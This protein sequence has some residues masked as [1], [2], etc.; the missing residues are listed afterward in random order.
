M[1]YGF[2]FNK[3]YKCFR[4]VKSCYCKDITP[5]DTGIKFVL[6]MHPK[7]AFKQK[8]GTGRLTSLSLIDSEIIIGTD[9]SRNK[10]VNA[11][12]SGVGE[13]AMYY[14]VL[15]FPSK[16]ASFADT[17]SFSQSIGS[18][19]LLVILI[20]A[21]WFLA[22]KML[23]FS[24]NLTHLP[25]LSFKNE[26]RSQFHIKLQPDPSYLSTIESTYYLINELKAAG[27]ARADADTSGLMNVFQK[28]VTFQQRCTQMRHEEEAM[29]IHPELFD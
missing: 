18:K 29:A 17:T 28:M 7:E 3:C 23:K 2:L 15:L 20:D 11:L 14:P 10:R 13:F 5:I 9:F 21:T 24:K 19:K 27:I 12:I 8:T 6:L 16:D 1:D 22:Q 26:Y 25:K 4:P